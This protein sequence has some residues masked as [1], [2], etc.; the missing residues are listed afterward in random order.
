MRSFLSWLR[1]PGDIS[2]FE[3]T[4]L[5][6]VNRVTLYFFLL[7]VPVFTL[8]AWANDTG[9]LL[10]LVLTSAVVVG[11]AAAHRTLKNPRSVGLVYG[12]TAMLMGG[13]LVH[14]GQGPVQIEMHFYF[15]ALLA[16]LALYGNPMAIVV[17]AVT[18]AAHHGLL[19]VFLPSSVFNYDAPW[20]VVGVHSLFVVLESAAAIYIA[21]S[22]FDNV[23]GLEKVVQ[24][25]T[26][27]LDSRNRA[28]RLVLDN[29]DQGLLTIDREGRV[30]SEYSAAI[31]RWFH[32]P[33]GSE[34][35]V[36]YLRGI[37][38]DLADDF[39]LAWEQCLE[40]FLPLDLCLAQAPSRFSFGGRSF[41]I[42]YTPVVKDDELSSLLLVIADVTNELERERLVVE[43]RETASIVERALSDR[44]GFREFMREATVLVRGARTETE[45]ATVLRAL[46]TLKGNSLIFGLQS[47][48][49]LCHEAECYMALEQGPPSAVLQQRL[50]QAV[51]RL[52]EQVTR[53]VGDW[54]DEQ[55]HISP[56]EYRSLLTAILE[57]RDHDSLAQ[58]VA[59]LQLEPAASRLARAV[60]QAQRIGSRLN[61]PVHAQLSAGPEVLLDPVRWASFWSA[62]VHVVRNALDHGVEPTDER[63]AQGKPETAQLVFA[64]EVMDGQL[65]VRAGDDGRGIAWERLRERAKRA[66]LAHETRADLVQALFTDGIST[67]AQVTEFSGRGVGLAAVRQACMELGGTVEVVSEPGRGSTFEFRFPRGSMAP[68]PRER[69][70]RLPSGSEEARVA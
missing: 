44:A 20:W 61:K 62:F 35:I 19:W 50:Q 6:R 59:D 31:D 10:A 3:W 32:A 30:Q 55:V 43:Q 60:E 27:E 65:V 34:A 36:G 39:E 56:A 15:F 25:R 66:G 51:E 67:A 28:M 24:V 1:L 5:G 37:C 48:A 38:G 16:M 23:I 54:R 53:L 26:E 52:D 8:I 58:Q 9:P 40:G 64:A 68:D 69:L 7:H 33:E 46:H 63:L 45:A 22:F 18:V 41:R 14:F 11:P 4:Y 29:I 12:F 2:P 17:A 70:A 57:R 21:R 42:S 47:L 13:L 49:D